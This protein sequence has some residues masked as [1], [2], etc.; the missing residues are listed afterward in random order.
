MIE[1]K[2]ISVGYG[3]QI[4]LNDLSAA[5]EK[6]KLT[7]VIG[8][9]GCGKSTL[10]KTILGMVPVSNGEI[11]IDG[12]PLAEMSRKDIARSIAYL[13][14]GKGTPDMTVEQLVLHGRFPHLSYPRRYTT[15]DREIAL[16]AMEQVGIT[17]YARKPLYTLSGGMR[18]N[19][20]I[21]MALTQGTDHILLDEPNTFLDISHQL[22]LM[23]RYHPNYEF[24][25][26][27]NS[28][29][30]CYIATAVY[31][32]YDCPEVWTLR[33]F[34][35]FTLSESWYGR[36]FIKIYYS[37]SPTLVKWFGQSAWFK[38]FLHKPLNSL[39]NKLQ[40]KGVENTP[41]KDKVW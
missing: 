6:G 30:G 20:Y 7:A 17:D 5:F 18:Q 38:N 11:A 21:A 32:S 36:A 8:V 10:L 31:G 4:V 41:Y 35:D 15:Q 25:V 23:K 37:I 3:K 9:N 40:Q 2:H 34:R 12:R 28:N 14:Q 33:R 16:A 1:L 29:G 19:A 26:T 13:S 39:V 22:E 27:A 24:P